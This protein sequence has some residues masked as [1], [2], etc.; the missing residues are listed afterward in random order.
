LEILIAYG[1]LNYFLSVFL[2]VQEPLHCSQ[3][4]PRKH[5]DMNS[6]SWCNFIFFA[7]G[8]TSIFFGFP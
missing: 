2:I 1:G 5:S 4:V 3:P 8:G 7:I 6:V